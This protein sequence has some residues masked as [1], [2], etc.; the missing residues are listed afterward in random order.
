M[1]TK[2]SDGLTVYRISQ[3]AT[4]H[5]PAVFECYSYDCS[6]ASVGTVE[7]ASGATRR[8]C[9]GHGGR[10]VTPAIQDGLDGAM[11]GG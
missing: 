6:E 3:P 1:M 8:A 9:A 5:S 11:Q 4:A 7:T 2:R 10:P